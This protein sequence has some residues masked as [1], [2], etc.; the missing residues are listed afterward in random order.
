MCPRW[1]WGRGC[2]GSGHRS[3]DAG[4]GARSDDAPPHPVVDALDAGAPAVVAVVVGNVVV[5]AVLVL[6]PAVEVDAA[7]I[8]EQP[9]VERPPAV[10]S[11]HGG[12]QVDNHRRAAGGQHD[13]LPAFVIA[14]G[15]DAPVPGFKNVALSCGDC[16]L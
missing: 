14:V 6:D 12:A 11:D 10:F 16:L 15:P 7:Q 4:A 3:T 13:V 5:A 1:T 9:A 2:A 8:V